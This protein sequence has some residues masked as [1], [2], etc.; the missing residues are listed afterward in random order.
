MTAETLQR[1]LNTPRLLYGLP[2]AELQE[3]ALRYPYAPNLRMLLLLKAHL[4]GHP[5]E[6]AYL[7]R[8]AAASFDRAHLWDVLRQLDK[9]VVKEESEEE[10]LELKELDALDLDALPEENVYPVSSSESPLPASAPWEPALPEYYPERGV[11][12]EKDEEPDLYLPGEETSVP[13]KPADTSS[14][15]PAEEE[16]P[17]GNVPVVMPDVDLKERLAR[18]RQRQEVRQA[19]RNKNDVNRIAR[20]SVVAQ[21]EVASETL[22]GLLV[23]QGQYQNAIRMYQRLILLNPEKKSIFAGLIKELKEKL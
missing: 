15:P 23:R 17:V 1:Y 21:E 6:E 18:I 12:Q 3:L 2:L 13:A 16:E 7:N 4:E 19:G 11:S 14:M 9:E 10:T 22:A 8:C 5:D 20:R